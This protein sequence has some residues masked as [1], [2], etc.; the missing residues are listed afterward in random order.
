[1]LFHN[2]LHLSQM[3]RKKL[4]FAI[5]V[6]WY[7]NLHWR[8]R[9][10][11]KMASGYGIHLCL[12]ETIENNCW[13]DFEFHRWK[14]SRSSISIWNNLKTLWGSIRILYSVRPDAIHSVTVKPNIMFGLL[15]L[16]AKKP[17]LM[18]I[19]GLG[20]IFSDDGMKAKIIQRVLLAMYSLTAKNSRAFFIFENSSDLNLFEKNGICSKLNASVVPGA[21]VNV[22]RFKKEPICWK[23]GGVLK[24]L[25]ASR[26]LKKK[27]LCELVD[28]VGE[29]KREGFPVV[30]NVAGL[31]D[32]D[33]RDTIPVSQVEYWH[34]EGKI[35]WLGQVDNIENVI[36]E[37]HVVVLPTSYGEGMP[38][39]LLEAN[40]C[41]RPVIATNIPGCS[42]FVINE[43][44][45]LLFEV[46]N[47]EEL[48]QS[49]RRFKDKDFCISIGENGRKL[50]EQHYTDEHV[51]KCYC[52]IYNKK[53]GR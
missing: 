39:I 33:S 29:L 43:E 31:L 13:A 21:G 4:L 12:S 22:S 1:M 23:K 15:A 5:N 19:P 17:I 7:F 14:L 50:V 26:L 42:D 41:G 48:K 24:L 2:R 20:T 35:N 45:G 51:L 36:A 3:N 40:A 44:N 11:S 32:N 30:L 49:I 10:L 8:D 25:F 18:T 16:I 47:H 52:E 27:G 46:G 38:R 34:R 53:L 37:N 9:L 28:A 6:D